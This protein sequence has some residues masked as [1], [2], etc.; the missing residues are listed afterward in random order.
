M[1][2]TFDGAEHGGGFH[3]FP[4]LGGLIGTEGLFVGG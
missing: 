4:D 1:N 2:A 3:D